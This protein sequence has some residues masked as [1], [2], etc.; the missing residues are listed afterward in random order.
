MRS[1][2]LIFI[3]ALSMAQIGMTAEPEKRRVNLHSEM[4]GVNGLPLA[5]S[6]EPVYRI[7]LTGIVDEQGEGEGFLIL[8]PTG[9]PE[10]DEFGFAGASP[11]V[12]VIKLDCKFK[13]M[14]RTVRTYVSRR[15]GAPD[16]EKIE[17]KQDWRLYSIT[18]PKITSRLYLSMLESRKWQE[19]RFLVKGND[20]KVRYVIDLREPPLPEPCHPGCFPA[21]T[22]IAIP[23]GAKAIEEINAG[24]IV[25]TVT[26]DGKFDQSAVESVFVTRNR[27]IHV[28]TNDGVL[29]TTTTQPLSLANGELGAAG[30]LKAGDRIHKSDGQK[31]QETAVIEVQPTDRETRV[32]NLILKDPVLF[33]ANNFLARSKPR[34]PDNDVVKP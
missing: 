23:G 33:V 21:G 20:D 3:V 1:R 24:D 5:E 19:G 4:I 14:K 2:R 32:F 29:T 12:P 7:R 17:Y 8:D 31:R 16:D 28:K 10:Y 6:T 9:P 26:S 11:D 25:I 15:L 34:I 18:G 13:R 22:V 30:T 27:L